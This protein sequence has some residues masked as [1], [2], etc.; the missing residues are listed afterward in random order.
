MFFYF[1][2]ITVCLIDLSSGDLLALLGYQS[3]W[4]IFITLKVAKCLDI[5]NFSMFVTSTCGVRKKSVWNASPKAYHITP[6]VKIR[7]FVSSLD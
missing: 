1:L 6:Q 2:K 3:C 5:S 7:Q 4:N